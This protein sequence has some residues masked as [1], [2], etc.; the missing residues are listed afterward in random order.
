MFN[1]VYNTVRPHV[2]STYPSS[3]SIIFRP[4]IQ[5]WHPSSTLCHE[6]A[7]AVLKLRPELFWPFSAKLFDKQ[8]DFF[9]VNVVRES[10]NQT[11][12]RLADIAADVGVDKAELLSYLH[13][14][15]KPIDGS[16]NVGNKVTDDLKKLVKA[17]RL[18]GVHVT[19]TVLFNVSLC[20]LGRCRGD[21]GG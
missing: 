13:V 9:D 19:P 1:T 3:V 21:L 6:A 18:V 15:D 5:P 11:Y 8:L 20:V 16:Y 17:N 2:A 12:E 4:Q 10:R 7:V 14:V